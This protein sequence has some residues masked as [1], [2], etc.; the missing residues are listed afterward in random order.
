MM[1]TLQAP[2]GDKSDLELRRLILNDFQNTSESFGRHSFL[3]RTLF[4][5]PAPEEKSVFRAIVYSLVVPGMGEL[6][7]GG[8]DSG[9]Y[10][11]IAE[12][13]LWLTFTSFELY[14]HWLENDARRFA[15]S[16]ASASI[17][18][19][20]D[21][22]FVNVGNFNNVYEYNEKKLR[23]RDLASVYDPS[24]PFF[25]LWD[26][27]QSRTRFRDLRV[28]SENIFN[29]VRFVVGAIIVNHIASAIN[30]A[31][32]ASARNKELSESGWEFQTGLLGNAL[33]PD[34]VVLTVRKT[35]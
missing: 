20:D 19:K 17:D 16:R 13:G 8:F 23:D 11:L 35:F 32:L 33:Y 10:F 27:E 25:W 9:K 29:N 22:F 4:Q 6:Y 3:S 18:G 5:S 15:A 7:A 31:R 26:N 30:A 34:G 28:K 14:G 12:T 1:G 2:A 24:G 21:Q